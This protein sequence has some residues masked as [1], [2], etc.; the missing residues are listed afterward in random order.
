MNVEHMWD[1]KPFGTAA[2][3]RP[4]VRHDLQFEPF[5]SKVIEEQLGPGCPLGMDAT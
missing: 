1:M 5:S 3:V 4:G 2:G